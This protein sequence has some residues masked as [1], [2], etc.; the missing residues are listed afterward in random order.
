MARACCLVCFLMVSCCK[1]CELNSHLSSSSHRHHQNRILLGVKTANQLNI[2]CMLD[3][4][5]RR[6]KFRI[7]TCHQKLTS[8]EPL[9]SFRDKVQSLCHVSCRATIV[10]PSAQNKN[11]RHSS[12]E[13]I[14]KVVVGIPN[15]RSRR[16]LLL[17]W[18]HR[19]HYPVVPT[20]TT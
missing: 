6:S 5:H 13:P 20:P 1:M 3:E 11:N 18:R 7:Y 17:L 12:L 15:L 10:L 4:R 8:L 9:N 2:F 14:G 16:L 19:R